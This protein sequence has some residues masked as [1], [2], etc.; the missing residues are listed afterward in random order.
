MAGGISYQYGT[1]ETIVK[2]C[3][4]EASIPKELAQTARNVGA[5]SYYTYTDCGL[6]PETQY[7]FDLAMPA[8]FK[9]LPKDG[10]V[11]CFYLWPMDKVCETILNGEW[12]PNCA[13]GK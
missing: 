7:I 5:V 1:H 3:D 4:E 11:D 6:Q 10:E 9:P 13:L 2:E 8:D 12:K